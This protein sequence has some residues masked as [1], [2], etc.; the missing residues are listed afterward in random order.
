MATSERAG[1]TICIIVC[2]SILP[3]CS[4]PAIGP[5]SSIAAAS[6]NGA[7]SAAATATAARK[8]NWDCQRIKRGIESLITAM[9]SAKERAEKEQELMAPTLARVFARVSGSPGAGNAALGEF[10]KLHGD[11]DQLNGLLREKGCAQHTIGV[12]APAFSK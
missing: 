3:G 2:L 6:S 5:D 8:Q 4:A 9:Q 7:G 11:A 10:R 12:D 1:A